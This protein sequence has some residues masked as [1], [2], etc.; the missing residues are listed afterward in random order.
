MS[1]DG[2]RFYRRGKTVFVT[3]YVSKS[4]QANDFTELTTLP[5]GWRPP[6]DMYFAVEVSGVA[7]RLFINTAGRVALYSFSS[8]NQ[9][10]GTVSFPLP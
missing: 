3:W 6:S 2:I 4:V 9:T 7:G 1:S 8:G 5:D 10:Q